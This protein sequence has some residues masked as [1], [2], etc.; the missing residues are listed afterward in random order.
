MS[1][2]NSKKT[3][4]WNYSQTVINS[5]K[6]MGINVTKY[7]LECFIEDYN[8]KFRIYVEVGLRQK[9]VKR[10][11]FGLDSDFDLCLHFGSFREVSKELEIE[12]DESIPTPL[13]IV[14][15]GSE[16]FYI[17][18]TRRTNYDGSLVNSLRYDIDP[19]N[20][21]VREV[22]NDDPNQK[23]VNAL[24]KKLDISVGT[25]LADIIPKVGSFYKSLS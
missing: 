3:D 16:G 24:R 21:F 23:L 14:A 17:R 15:S 11:I 10:Y 8:G 9:R 19:N 6:S 4:T 25:C 13:E 18:L 5:L 7:S 1:K 22:S 2:N 20:F 12:K